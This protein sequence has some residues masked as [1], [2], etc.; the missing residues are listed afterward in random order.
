MLDF[1]LGGYLLSALQVGVGNGYQLR[2]RDQAANIQSVL[3]TH[4]ADPN[5]THAQLR[6]N[7]P[8]I[9]GSAGI[10]PAVARA[11]CPRR[12]GRDAPTTDA[13]TA[14]LHLLVFDLQR[15][16]FSG[17]LIDR[18][19][20]DD[21]PQTLLAVRLRF[22]AFPNA[23]REIVEFQSE[24]VDRLEYLG[25]PAPRNLSAKPPLFLESE[26]WSQ[27]GPAFLPMNMDERGKSSAVGCGPLQNEAAAKIQAERDTFFYLFISSS[28]THPIDGTA[29]GNRVLVDQPAAGVQT[30]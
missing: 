29:G 4:R 19:N 28:I 15:A 6:H 5:Y 1:E 12:W 20:D 9:P 16:A 14:A 3:L 22:A 27:L 21:V 26:G 8:F 7:R 18:V 11:S 23:L 30:V 17:G 25:E 2:F 24:F 13:G 10:L